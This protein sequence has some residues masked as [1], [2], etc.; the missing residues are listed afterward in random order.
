MMNLGGGKATF[1]DPDGNI[2]EIVQTDWQKY[3]S[4]S[5]EDVKK[6]A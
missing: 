3:F 1:A 2:L 4:I 5:A 6:K